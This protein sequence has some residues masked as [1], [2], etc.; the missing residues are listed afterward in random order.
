MASPKAVRIRIPKGDGYDGPWVITH[1]WLKLSLKYG[2]L[3]PWTPNWSVAF[4]E[5]SSGRGPSK[6]PATL[7]DMAVTTLMNSRVKTK[8]LKT[9]TNWL[10]MK[11]NRSLL[12]ELREAVLSSNGM[13]AFSPQAIAKI[14]SSID[15]ML[16]DRAL[17][18]IRLAKVFKW[19]SA[20]AP[21][22]IPMIDRWVL[23]ALTNDPK[24]PP[25]ASVLLSRFQRLLVTHHDGLSGLATK[26]SRRTSTTVSPVRVLD[27]V[28]WFDWWACYTYCPIFRHWVIPS[29]RPGAMEHSV[30][31]TATAYAR[32]EGWK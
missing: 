18:D 9:L 29:S 32:S 22:H 28:I 1:P 23:E 4:D 13:E 24:R 8:N 27:S 6:G 11:A 25:K 26:L 14:G 3:G 2:L 16:A 20:W 30:T 12:S 15:L 7:A 21:H 5:Y 10:Q 19:L 31:A 17:P